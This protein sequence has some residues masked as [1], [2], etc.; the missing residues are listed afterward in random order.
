MTPVETASHFVML[1]SMVESGSGPKSKTKDKARIGWREVVELPE[2][3]VKAIR[4]KVD[5]G[6]RTS[7]LHAENI[8]FYQSRGKHKVRFSVH[9]QIARKNIVIEAELIGKRVVRS[10]IGLSTYRPVIRTLLKI[11]NETWPIEVTL[12]NRDLM[13][14]PMLLGRTAIRG[15]F[16][17]DPGRSFLQTPEKYRSRKSPPKK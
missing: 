14:F 15:R 7:A 16:C 11:G 4:V 12:V 5:S 2:L 17:I 6:A 10:S 9:P 13:G 3:N 8:E 1:R